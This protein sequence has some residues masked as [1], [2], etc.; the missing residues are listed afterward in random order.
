MAGSEVL[1]LHGVVLPGAHPRDVYVVGGR[2][3]FAPQQRARTVLTAGYLVPGLVDAHAHLSLHSPAG[4]AA[5]PAERVRASARAQLAAGVLALREPGSP[6]D[7]S[8]EVGPHLGLPRTVTAGRLLAAPGRYFPG[9]ALEVTA[10]QLPGAAEAQ[11][12]AS[13]AWC[14]VIADFPVAGGA[15]EPAFPPAALVEAAQRVHAVGARI[16]AHASGTAA[17]EAVVE[18][19]FDSVEHATLLREEHLGELL[20]RGTAIVPTLVIRDGILAAVAGTGASSRV[21]ARLRADLDAQPGVVREA[22]ARGVPV[23]AGTDA[24]MVAHGLVATEVELLRQ[25]GLPPEQ[26]SVPRRGRPA[27]TSGCRGWSTAPPPTWWRTPTTRAA[28]RRSCARRC[29]SSWTATCSPDRPVRPVTDRPC[30]GPPARPGHSGGMTLPGRAPAR[31]HA[32]WLT[33]MDGVLMHEGRALSPGADAFIKR[34]RERASAVPGADQQLHL[35]P[36]RPAA[37]L[38]RI[39]LEVPVEAIWT[40]ALAT[41]QFL[42]DQRPGGTAYVI[43]EAGLTTALH[44]IGYMLT[45][46]APDYVVLG[47]T[48]TTPSRRMTKAI[49]LIDGGARF[50]ATNPDETGPSP[51]ARC[52]RPG[53]WPR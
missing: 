20:A 26:P 44:D 13:G 31:D 48:R 8:R 35:H 17:I 43:G 34:L 37:R 9:L 10:G 41:A 14:K 29:C 49:R 16:A 53:R 11:A 2:L 18:A 27:P 36:A 45:D 39:G 40:S 19:G 12:R 6:D 24:G 51:R 46:H 1:H 47:E 25:A 3:S 21:L 52:P 22:A 38:A 50:I 23:L 4:D 5:A 7:A 33:D 15:V 42:D 30:P 28:T 32:C